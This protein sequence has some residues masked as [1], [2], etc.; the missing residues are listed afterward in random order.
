[1][2]ILSYL[3]LQVHWLLRVWMIRKKQPLSSWLLM[4]NRS[5]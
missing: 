1:M 4:V 3:T 5:T 2:L